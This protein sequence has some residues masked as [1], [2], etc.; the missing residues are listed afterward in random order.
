MSLQLGKHV[1]VPDMDESCVK[2]V[3]SS[4]GFNDPRAPTIIPRVK[5]C[6][7]KCWDF[8]ARQ[9]SGSYSL[10]SIGYTSAIMAALKGMST[11]CDPEIH[12]IWR[13]FCPRDI[14]KSI[15]SIG[16]EFNQLREEDEGLIS[17]ASFP[18]Y[19]FMHC[20]FYPRHAIKVGVHDPLPWNITF[21]L[22][23]ATFQ[24]NYTIAD[25]RVVLKGFGSDVP[26]YA[27]DRQSELISLVPVDES[28]AGVIFN[29]PRVFENDWN[30]SGYKVSVNTKQDVQ[31]LMYLQSIGV[32]LEGLKLSKKV[33]PAIRL[34]K[35]K[36]IQNPGD[37][38]LK[39]EA[40]R[41]VKKL[42]LS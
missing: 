35:S 41:A 8:K 32:D 10:G 12:V 37:D 21:S 42:L 6:I 9:N 25:V 36:H 14:C 33:K 26:T 4:G 28:A 5:T 7:T 23:D 19:L 29:R 18:A 2:S 24:D 31:K 27:E 1:N 40:S 38:S 34:I 11:L 16:C 13:S 20:I 22:P 17:S 15:V 3:K 39:L 30:M